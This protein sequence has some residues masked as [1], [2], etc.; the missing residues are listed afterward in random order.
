[1]PLENVQ[2]GWRV[3]N[4]PVSTKIRLVY[5]SI[6]NAQRLQ[7]R[8]SGT[9]DDLSYWCCPLDDSLYWDKYNVLTHGDPPGM[10]SWP[11]SKS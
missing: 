4:G 5:D 9:K 3:S 6:S 2:V 1:M 10:T 11:P 8:K 7:L